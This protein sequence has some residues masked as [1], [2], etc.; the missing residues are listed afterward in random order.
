MLFERMDITF[1]HTILNPQQ[2]K[3]KSTS[4]RSLK[5]R[6]ISC[7]VNLRRE[8]NSRNKEAGNVSKKH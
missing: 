6:K 3:T 7:I 5:T 2:R 1:T 8:S 4:E